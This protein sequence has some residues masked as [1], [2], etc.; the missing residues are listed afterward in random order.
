MEKDALQRFIF[1]G[2]RVRG[3]L[4][5]L[6]ES[7]Q[8][9]LRR[10]PY[11]EPLRAALG[12]LMAA[13]ALL[14]AT[15]K[16]EGG[17]LVL[18][19]QRGTPL[20][21]LV[22]ECQA[23]LTLRATAHWE[24]DLEAMGPAT[25]LR[26]MARGGQCVLTIDP[27]PGR[28]AYQSVV[29]LEGARTSDVLERYMARSEQIETRFALAADERRASGLLVQKLPATAGAAGD[30][31][32]L[33]RRAEALLAT[34]TREELLDLPGQ[35]ILRRLFHEEALQVFESL[36]VRFACRC[37]RERVAGMLRMLGAGEA[38]GLADEKGEVTV[39]CDFCREQYVYT[40][41]QVE[42]ALGDAEG[43]TP[44]RA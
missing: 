30:D 26:G 41:E 20:T 16:F 25:T 27:G 15:L 7:W 29:P 34:L 4:V 31:E 32:D 18:Q 44:P 3:E 21:L 12:E 24:A 8:D 36:P 11:P 23:D 2:A 42:A 13:T 14:A 19:V 1:E 35:E 5:R 10:R 9:V 33:W 37:S 39:T 22:I 38:R 6:D 43:V 28:Q 40:R 17:A